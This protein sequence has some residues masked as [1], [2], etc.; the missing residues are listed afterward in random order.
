[1]YNFFFFFLQYVLFEMNLKN[2][3][4]CVRY[5]WKEKKPSATIKKNEAWTIESEW[6]KVMQNWQNLISNAKQSKNKTTCHC[7]LIFPHSSINSF[8]IIYLQRYAGNLKTP[9]QWKCNENAEPRSSMILMNARQF[10]SKTMWFD[11]S[12]CPQQKFQ[13]C[14]VH[15]NLINANT[16]KNM[17]NIRL[18]I[19]CQIWI[20]TEF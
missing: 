3:R 20:S 16:T 19:P 14:T 8:S 5:G 12:W 6:I 10:S 2:K 9:T 7:V 1:M 11:M 18:D 17:S 15:Y 13:H 4:K